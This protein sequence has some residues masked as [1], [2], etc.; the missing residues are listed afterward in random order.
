MRYESTKSLAI[1]TIAAVGGLTTACVG[2]TAPPAVEGCD[3]NA[4][5]WSVWVTN[6][7]EGVDTVTVF[8]NHDDD[9]DVTAEILA[10]IPVGRGP[11]NVVFSPDGRQAWVA[12]LGTPPDNGFITVI[13]TTS[14]EIVAD[15][16][17]GVKPH[18]LGLTPDGRWAWVANVGSDDIT[19]IDTATFAAEPD[20]I[21]VGDGPALVVFLPDGSKAY[22]SNGNDGTTSVIDVATRE[23][24]STISTG[25]GAMGLVVSHDGRFVIETEGID[26]QVSVIDTETDTVVNVLRFDDALLEAHGLALAGNQLLITNRTGNALSFVD[27]ETLSLQ[28]SVSV[29]GRPDI[30][31]VSPDCDRAYL[32]LRDVPAVAVVDIVDRRYLGTIPFEGGDLHGVAVLTEHPE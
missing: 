3:P 6:Q 1:L 14:Y 29:P 2:D 10:T 7:G 17:A 21:V 9:E 24:L 25:I 5:D 15:I 30:I 4:T 28:G 22:V 31:G 18:G 27:I 11:H 16:E 13:D 32:T 26:N 20:R 19:I 12:I 8:H 23:L